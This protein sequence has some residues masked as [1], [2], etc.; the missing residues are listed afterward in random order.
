MVPHYSGTTL[1]AQ[2]RYAAG[3]K[4][5]LENYFTGKAQEPADVIVGLGKYETKACKSQSLVLNEV[6]TYS[7]NF[8]MVNVE[9]PSSLYYYVCNMYGRQSKNGTPSSICF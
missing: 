7:F 3:T 1:D 8:Q 5:I 2:A 4:K 9:E 6:N